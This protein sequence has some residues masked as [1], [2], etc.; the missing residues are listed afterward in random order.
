[1]YL[2]KPGSLVEI[3]DPN[4]GV[5]ASASKNGGSHV[6]LAG[7][8]RTDYPG[9]TAREFKLSWGGGPNYL[10]A[11]QYD[12]L[13]QCYEN[14]GPWVLQPYSRYGVWNYAQPSYPNWTIVS[15]D[16]GAQ[17]YQF[18][19]GVGLYRTKGV[20]VSPGQT[21]TFQATMTKNSGTTPTF[22]PYLDWYTE[23]GTSPISSTAGTTG[24]N[25]SAP[26][27]FSLT[28]TAPAT[29]AFVVPRLQ[30]TYTDVAD[31]SFS[32]V[33]LELA[34]TAS[35]PLRGRGCPLVSFDDL[36]LE[37]NFSFQISASATFIDVS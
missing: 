2:G 34:D 19:P 7:R 9:S 31:S 33:Q 27:S 5:T 1:M 25:N 12:I 36:T 6:T 11:A 18:L 17:A 16:V 26:W 13:E 3:P 28:G 20:P 21:W 37:Y 30:G 8:N 4:P 15:G 14:P 23:T 32:G 24:S 35:A 29:A 22:T 10:S